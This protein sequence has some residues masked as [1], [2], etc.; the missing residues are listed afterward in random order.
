LLLLTRAPLLFVSHPI[1]TSTS[2]GPSRGT[3]IM[4]R[5]LDEAEL[6]A[7]A[8]QT[9]L[10][11]R[12]IRLDWEPLQELPAGSRTALALQGQAG[13]PLDGR[14]IAAYALLPDVYGETAL[15]LRSVIPREVYREGLTTIRSLVLSLLGAGVL[16]GALTMFLLESALLRRLSRLNREVSDIG[17]R[18]D[19]Y[20]RRAE[21]TLWPRASAWA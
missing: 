9:R 11:L 16:F 20:S 17:L 13:R 19:L 3:L 18:R 15:V 4:G 10:D 12:L 14:R 8:E 7:L 6:A 21:V 5:Y 1:L 2:G